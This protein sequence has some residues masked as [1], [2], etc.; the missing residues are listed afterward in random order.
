MDK[1]SKSSPGRSPTSNTPGRPKET[2]SRQQTTADQTSQSGSASLDKEV[3]ARSKTKA[4]APGIRK[5][6]KR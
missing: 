4:L 5:P 3:T 2:G 6:G 1:A